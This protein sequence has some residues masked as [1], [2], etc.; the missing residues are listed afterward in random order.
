MLSTPMK[1]R[2]AVLSL[3]GLA[4]AIPAAP[5]QAAPTP[6]PARVFAPYFETWQPD[7]ISGI[8]QQSGARYFTLAFLAPL[9]K[10]SCPLAWDESTSAAGASGQHLS[11]I[12]SLRAVGGDVLASFG[13]WS[14]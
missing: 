5:A 12:T 8:A 3:L 6:L 9:T 14:A 1:R 4:L 2:L 10:T 13:G 7:T 11:D